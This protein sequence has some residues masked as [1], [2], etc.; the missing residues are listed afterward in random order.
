MLPFVVVM[1]KLMEMLVMLN[2][3]VFLIIKMALVNE[4]SKI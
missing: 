2:V 4:K 1:A 3:T